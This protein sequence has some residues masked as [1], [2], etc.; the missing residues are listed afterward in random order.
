[1]SWS[2]ELS[3]RLDVILF[4]LDV[5]DRTASLRNARQKLNEGVDGALPP[6]R[7]SAVSP[8]VDFNSSLRWH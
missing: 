5:L 1:M 3:E 2:C 6:A 4:R 8:L 7:T